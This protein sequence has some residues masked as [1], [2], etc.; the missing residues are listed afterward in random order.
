MVAM[1]NNRRIDDYTHEK[2]M[3]VA[4]KLIVSAL[5]LGLFTL[6]F[7]GQESLGTADPNVLEIGTIRGWLR[8]SFFW[9]S[10]MSLVVAGMLFSVGIIELVFALR[11][12]ARSKLGNE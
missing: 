4:Q 12:V 11:L 8:G 1:A 6:L 9:G 10:A 5:L 3:R 7:M 2:I